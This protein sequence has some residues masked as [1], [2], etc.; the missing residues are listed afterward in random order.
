M[1]CTPLLIT[2]AL[3]AGCQAPISSTEEDSK[4]PTPPSDTPTELLVMSEEEAEAPALRVVEFQ[5][6]RLKNG[7]TVS[8]RAES[9]EGFADYY[10]ATLTFSHPQYNTLVVD[11]GRISK[12]RLEEIERYVV[13]CREGVL[14]APNHL[15]FFADIDFDGVEEI[16]TGIR[17][18]GGRQHNLP[19]YSSVYQRRGREYCE[20]TDELAESLPEFFGESPT[21]AIEPYLFQVNPARKELIYCNDGGAIEFSYDI[22][23]YQNGSYHHDRRVKYS[24][25]EDLDLWDSVESPG[26]YIEIVR[27]LE[28]KEEEYRAGHDYR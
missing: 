5:I 22:F 20:I 15:F 10:D 12:W 23:S 7:F 19:A 4:A 2:L 13:E 27:H 14:I 21:H 26:Y 3:M 18:F 17:P 9:A 1:K 16:I 24:R 6:P 28:I 25:T 11:G 8:G